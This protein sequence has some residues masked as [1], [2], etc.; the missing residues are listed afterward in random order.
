MTTGHV[1]ALALNVRASPNGAI[2]NVLRQN[3]TVQ[4]L[5]RSDGWLNI[6]A[7]Q[8]GA[9]IAG[10]VSADFVAEA[11][12][13][14]PATGGQPRTIANGIAWFKK[15]FGQAVM[16]GIAGTPYS[17]DF[18]AAIAVQETF[19]VWGNLFTTMSPPDILKLC[20]GDTLDAPDRSQFPLTKSDLLSKPS[21]AA[22]F[23]IARQALDL[24]GEHNAAYRRVAAANPDK[25]CHGFGIFQYDLQHF[26]TDPAFFLQQRWFD[27][28]ACIEKAVQELNAA[29]ARAY[30]AGKA[31]L[32]DTEMVYVAIAYN[33][34]S[35]NINSDFKQGFRDGSGK[36]YGE[37]TAE[38]LQA[39]QNT[40]AA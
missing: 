2:L 28:P 20:V 34:G 40:P 6:A 30:G 39:A 24:I 4:I 12:V 11:P 3:C 29:K 23:Q 36:F 35:V 8:D 19:E 7:T 13:P 26:L 32:T 15:N 5:Q 31:T 16:T 17:L 10:W 21:G 27:I 38:Y 14:P 25:F 18:M 1:T 33:R 37:L 9:N 22:C